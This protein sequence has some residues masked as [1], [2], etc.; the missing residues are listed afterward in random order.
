ML[1]SAWSIYKNST[2]WN[3][4]SSPSSTSNSESRTFSLLYASSRILLFVQALSSLRFA[5]YFAQW[6]TGPS[7][8]VTTATT[9]QSKHWNVALVSAQENKR[10]STSI[11]RGRQSNHKTCST[12]GNSDLN[13]FATSSRELLSWRT[14]RRQLRL[15]AASSY[16]SVNLADFRESKVLL[17]TQGFVR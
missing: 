9:D 1:R 2:W 14:V 6:K 10:R 16:R 15:Y 7:T 13:V 3:T 12:A 17:A 5:S 11:E 4:S 8:I